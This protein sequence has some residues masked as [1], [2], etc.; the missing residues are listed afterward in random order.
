MY[1]R[2]RF[3]TFFLHCRCFTK[4]K[5]KNKDTFSHARFKICCTTVYAKGLPYK[6]RFSSSH[7]KSEQAQC[8][9]KVIREKLKSG[10]P[11]L[12]PINC[13]TK[14]VDRAHMKKVNEKKESKADR[15]KILN[16][17][18]YISTPIDCNTEGV[19]GAQIK[20]KPDKRKYII[21][22]ALQFTH[23]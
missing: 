3:L 20:S 23:S 13:N 6:A 9:V 8:E 12:T 1:V 2:D 18:Y 15:G 10:A 19:D 5:I 17:A 16:L 7:K 11:Q 4:I 14:D 22:G 21:S